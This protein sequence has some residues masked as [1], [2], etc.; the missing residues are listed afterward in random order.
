MVGLRSVA[1]T[2]VQGTSLICQTLMKRPMRR[3][4]LYVPRVETILLPYFAQLNHLRGPRRDNVCH[5][6]FLSVIAN[7]ADFTT[8]TTNNNTVRRFGSIC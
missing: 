1:W 7:S 2:F 5:S 4:K 6:R 8:S 3:I